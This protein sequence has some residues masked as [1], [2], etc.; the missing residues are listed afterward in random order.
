MIFYNILVEI[1]FKKFKKL[2][3]LNKLGNIDSIIFIFKQ[4]KIFEYRRDIART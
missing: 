1:L 2:I 4:N 3:H